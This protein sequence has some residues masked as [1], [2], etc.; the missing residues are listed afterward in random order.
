MSRRRRLLPVAAVGGVVAV[1]LAAG[2]TNS[3][4]TGARADTDFVGWIP[5]GAASDTFWDSPVIDLPGLSLYT[6]HC[7]GQ[8]RVD[9][10][11]GATGPPMSNPCYAAM[12]SFSGGSSEVDAYIFLGGGKALYRRS[13]NYGPWTYYVGDVITGVPPGEAGPP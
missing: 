2:I 11:V 10:Q 13:D 3:Y 1:M 5:D 6:I 4:G 7:H 9:F 8:M 12:G